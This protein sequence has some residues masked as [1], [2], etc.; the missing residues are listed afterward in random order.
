MMAVYS[1][2]GIYFPVDITFGEKTSAMLDAV[3][4]MPSF[5]KTTEAEQVESAK[6]T[7]G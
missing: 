5:L 1:T 2:W 6:S 3:K 7:K 4:A